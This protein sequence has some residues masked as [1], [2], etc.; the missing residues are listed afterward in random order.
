VAF[1]VGRLNSG[2]AD[3]IESEERIGGLFDNDTTAILMS[4]FRTSTM[5]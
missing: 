3:G 1:I 5:V 4:L 2:G